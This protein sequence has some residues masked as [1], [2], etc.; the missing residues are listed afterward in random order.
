MFTS[1]GRIVFVMFSR[2]G[3]VRG[4]D[5]DSSVLP[6]FLSEDLKERPNQGFGERKLRQESSGGGT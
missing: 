4:Y 1:S 2:R 6:L 3:G 5:S